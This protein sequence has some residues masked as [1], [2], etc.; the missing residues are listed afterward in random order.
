MNGREYF[1]SSSGM[2]NLLHVKS[3]YVLRNMEI[4]NI[5]RMEK[6][7]YDALIHSRFMA[8]IAFSGGKIS[9]HCTI[10]LCI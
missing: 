5:P 1:F 3:M 2:H 7:E 10:P 8:R 4:V 6:E 9:L